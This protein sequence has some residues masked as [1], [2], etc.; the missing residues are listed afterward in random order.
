MIVSSNPVAIT[1]TSDIAP[2]LSKEFLDIQ[3]TIECRFTLKSVRDMIITYIERNVINLTLIQNVFSGCLNRVC[4]CEKIK[5]MK[6]ELT[7]RGNY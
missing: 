2:V 1:Y 3:A 5:L 4:F 6:L 7:T